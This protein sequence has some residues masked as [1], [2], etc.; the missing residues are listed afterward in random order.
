MHRGSRS[1]RTRAGRRRRSPVRRLPPDGERAATVYIAAGTNFVTWRL[2]VRRR[3][4]QRIT[5]ANIVRH[6]PIVT[7]HAARARLET[8]ATCALL[9]S[10]HPI[11]LPARRRLR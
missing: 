11:S 9:S 6:Q 8:S 2:P 1:A 7:A 10:G 3:D 4:S 5:D